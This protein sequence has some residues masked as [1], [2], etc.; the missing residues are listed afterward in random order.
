VLVL[1]GEQARRPQPAEPPGRAGQ[2]RMGRDSK[3]KDHGGA[4]GA[5]ELELPVAERDRGRE[6]GH[7]ALQPEDQGRALDASQNLHA[8]TTPG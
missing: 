6:Q 1:W 2:L 8:D 5:L 4:P 7:A 3:S